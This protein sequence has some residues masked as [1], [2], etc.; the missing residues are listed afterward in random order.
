VSFPIPI[1]IFSFLSQNSGQ[2]L[3][4]PILVSVF[5][6]LCTSIPP[7][8][9][10][11]HERDVDEATLL[12]HPH[13]YALFRA[14]DDFT[15]AR[16]CE[17]IAQGMWEGVCLY[18]V[19]WGMQTASQG[20]RNQL[21]G[22]NDTLHR[23]GKDAGM[24]LEGLLVFTGLVVLTNMRM[25]TSLNRLT[26]YAAGASLL[27]VALLLFVAGVVSAVNFDSFAPEGWGAL[28]THGDKSA[29]SRCV[30]GSVC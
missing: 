30:F 2:V 3:Y 28:M 29:R 26:Y 5:N 27:G 19:L 10:G 9:A 1:L 13:A 25:F 8:V 15:F 24:W 17:W 21:G 16:F 14:A 4:L 6:L 12:R 23:D 11:V 7:L 20:T 18:F 22:G